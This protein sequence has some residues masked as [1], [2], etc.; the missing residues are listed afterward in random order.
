M[1]MRDKIRTLADVFVDEIINVIAAEM[2]TALESR[3]IPP[4]AKRTMGA[5]QRTTRAVRGRA[6]G[7]KRDP[8]ALAALT[9]T[10]EAAIRANP[11]VGIERIGVA[12]GIATKELA[13]PVKKLLADGRIKTKGQ[14]RA[15]KYFPAGSKSA[16]SKKRKA[17]KKPRSASK[18]KAPKKTSKK[19]PKKK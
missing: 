16:P 7:A 19:T 17:P 15:T 12:T 2:T 14:R 10:L 8:K 3:V 11:G 13:L 9:E 1:N 18:K 6:K 5:A 4:R